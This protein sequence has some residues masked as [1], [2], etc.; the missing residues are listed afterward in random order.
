MSYVDIDIP[1][2]TKKK[3]ID[4]LLKVAET[5]KIRKGMNETTKAIERG[6]A[7][8]VVISEDVDPPEVV[9]HIPLL[10]GEKDTPYA[11]VSTKT[12][13]GKACGL[14]V[15]CSAIAV[16]DAGNAEDDLQKLG[17]QIGKLK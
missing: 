1:D 9:M 3:I 4:A 12:E 14:E 15:G 7:K 5:G 6:T 2:N 17:D 8:F 10:C 11:F 16:L 13:L